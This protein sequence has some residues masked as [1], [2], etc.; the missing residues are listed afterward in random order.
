MTILEEIQD[1]IDRGYTKDQI[2]QITGYE[3]EGKICA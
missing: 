3:L 2:S 1:F